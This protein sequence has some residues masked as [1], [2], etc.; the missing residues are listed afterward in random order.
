VI[1]YPV[2]DFTFSPTNPVVGDKVTFTSTSTGSISSYDWSFGDGATGSGGSVSH[3]YTTAGTY[4]VTLTIKD[5]RGTT[6]SASKPI[7]I[8]RPQVVASFSYSPTNP[9]EGDTV[10]FDASASSGDITSWTWNFGDGGTGSGKLVDHVFN[11]AGSY[12]VSLTVSDGYSSNTAY[13]T[14]NVQALTPPVINVLTLLEF[15]PSTQVDIKIYV[16]RDASPLSGATVTLNI[17]AVPEANYGGTTKSSST[18][19]DGIAIIT[20]ISPPTSLY[21][22]YKMTISCLSVSNTY[23]LKVLPQILVKTTQFNYEQTYKPGDYDFIYSGQTV[24][25]ESGVIVSDCALAA[26]ELKDEAGNVIAATYTYYDAS[27]GAF[28]FK[29]KVYDYYASIN[30][31]FNYEIKT[32]TLTLT[33]AKTGYIK[34]TLNVTAKIGPPSIVAVIGSTSITVGTNSFKV[35]FKDKQGQ[36]YTGLTASN[37]EV[38]ITTPSGTTM[39]TSRELSSKYYFD[40][41]TKTIT[42]SYDFTELG[43][44]KITVNYFGLPFTQASQ[45]FSVSCVQASVI[46]PI[47]TNPYVLGFIG[48]IIL[49]LLLRRRKK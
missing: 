42:V 25:K 30:P 48:L 4:T 26:K 3:S 17:P 39:S 36:P 18:G 13:Q 37:I 35:A 40:D 44:Y 41:S 23:D 16:T 19:S 1:N 14:V 2:A 38:I 28:T 34:G 27:G 12:N 8:S 21:S 7:T 46:P 22:P 5:V 47:L 29:A 49:I 10:H 6:K 45:T 20:I 31:N 32:L 9:R 15:P 43:T 33:F 24:D 11:L